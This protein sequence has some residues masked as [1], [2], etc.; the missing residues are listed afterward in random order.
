[1]TLM[2]G[3]RLKGSRAHPFTVMAPWTQATRQDHY[4]TPVLRT[5]SAITLINTIHTMSSIAIRTKRSRSK[6]EDDDSR[7]SKRT[8]AS[9]SAGRQS[10]I[11]DPTVT[12]CHRL[13]ENIR[14]KLRSVNREAAKACSWE[15][16]RMPLGAGVT[17]DCFGSGKKNYVKATW[18]DE[19]DGVWLNTTIQLEPDIRP[20]ITHSAYSADHAMMTD[21]DPDDPDR[22]KLDKIPEWVTSRLG[23][24]FREEASRLLALQPTSGSSYSKPVE[25]KVVDSSTG[26]QSVLVGFQDESGDM[27]DEVVERGKTGDN[28]SEAMARV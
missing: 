17:W 22:P 3:C 12:M 18:H 27:E 14:G 13:P 1:M 21:Q 2:K 23:L 25:W 24:S 15:Y 10:S 20:S 19:P 16:D 4:L 7:E 28:V 5:T 26:A 6:D 9:S 8:T 11:V